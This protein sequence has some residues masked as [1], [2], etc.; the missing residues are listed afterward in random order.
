MLVCRGRRRR[1]RERL[2]E[3]GVRKLVNWV[4]DLGCTYEELVVAAPVTGS[5][6]AH[7]RMTLIGGR[8]DERA[9]EGHKIVKNGLKSFDILTSKL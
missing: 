4:Y 3:V 2:G 7:Y 9:N 1:A 5:G 6:G 8:R